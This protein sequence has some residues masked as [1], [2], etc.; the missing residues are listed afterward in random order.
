MRL[1]YI[2]LLS[3]V[4]RALLLGGSL[5]LFT[6]PQVLD[7]QP[8]L[9]NTQPLTLARARMHDSDQWREVERHLPDPNTATPQILEQQ[10]DVLR[11]RRFPEDALDYYHY[12]LA[13]G[14]NP[15]VLTNKM[16][17]THLEMKDY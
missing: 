13:R 3:P 9:G 10:A 16:G 8:A 14:G 17:L 11:A 15:V 6:T 7:A 5:A 4:S 1:L 2:F 12:A